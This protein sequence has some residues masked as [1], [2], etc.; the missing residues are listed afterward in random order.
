M[1]RGFKGVTSGEL[2][3]V[4]SRFPTHAYAQDANMSLIEFS[5]FFYHC[6]FA[7]LEDPLSQWEQMQANQER[8]VNW[9]EGKKQVRI[10]GKE[11]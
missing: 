6:S 4:V 9:L 5:D 10:F 7:D 2:R 11:Y 8:L 3:W 1:T